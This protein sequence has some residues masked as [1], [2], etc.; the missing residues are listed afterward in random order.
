MTTFYSIESFFD[1]PADAISFWNKLYDMSKDVLIIAGDGANGKTQ[2][3][4]Q[5]EKST[6]KGYFHYVNE[7]SEKSISSMNGKVIVV[8]NDVESALRAIPEYHNYDVVYF[9]KRFV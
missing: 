3:V 9:S 6:P 7:G 4:K 2:M 8:T 5:I 1:N